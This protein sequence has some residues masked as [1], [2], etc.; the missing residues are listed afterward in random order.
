M[1]SSSNASN[2]LAFM[3][4]VVLMT[5]FMIHTNAI[6]E[7]ISQGTSYETAS[8]LQTNDAP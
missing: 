5:T 6:E 1:V 8:A 4:S 2:R 3:L 7:G